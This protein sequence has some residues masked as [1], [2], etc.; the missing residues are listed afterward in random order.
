MDDGETVLLHSQ[1]QEL[2]TSGLRR[3]LL[4][5]ADLTQVDSSG[6]GTIVKEYRSIRDQ[7]GDLRLLRPSGHALEVFRALHLLAIIPSFDEENLA[8]ASFSPVGRAE[9]PQGL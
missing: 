5:L 6:V 1:L 2:I 4:N 9:K 3:F 7:G 8:L